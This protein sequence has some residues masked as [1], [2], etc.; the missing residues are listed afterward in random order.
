M[1]VVSTLIVC[2]VEPGAFAVNRPKAAQIAR[3]SFL[4]CRKN[5]LVIQNGISTIYWLQHAVNHFKQEWRATD[6]A[7]TGAAAIAVPGMVTD[8]VRIGNDFKCWLPL[9]VYLHARTLIHDCT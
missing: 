7:T 9:A 5:S 1:L 4:R 6:M 3:P 2:R 8:V